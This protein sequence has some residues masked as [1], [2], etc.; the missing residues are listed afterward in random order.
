M[1]Q[2]DRAPAPCCG[3]QGPWPPADFTGAT[4]APVLRERENPWHFLKAVVTVHVGDQ[5]RKEAL[6]EGQIQGT[7]QRQAGRT[8]HEKEKGREIEKTSRSLPGPRQGR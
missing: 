6:A 5:G 2:R 7:L 1:R 8:G 4:L 3:H